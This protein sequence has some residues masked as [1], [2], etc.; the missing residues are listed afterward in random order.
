MKKK[1]IIYSLLLLIGLI[2]LTNCSSNEGSGQIKSNE[3][4]TTQPTE[5]PT[6]PKVTSTPEAT[7]TPEPIHNVLFFE[8]D[9]SQNTLDWEAR[10]GV[11][12]IGPDGLQLEMAKNEAMGPYQGLLAYPWETLQ[13]NGDCTFEVMMSG[14]YTFSGPMFNPSDDYYS[15][16]LN[17]TSV[18]L[19]RPSLG[20]K[21]WDA[22]GEYKKQT[23]SSDNN[24]T[25]KLVFI[26]N[27]VQVY[28]NDELIATRTDEIFDLP[29]TFGGFFVVNGDKFGVSEIKVWG[30]TLDDLQI[31]SKFVNE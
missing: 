9:F 7:A 23:S 21:A 11:T 3:V 2:G 31:D 29:K 1:L 22:L 20:D 28:V 8:E 26:G 27:E 4:P 18:G 16:I 12:N 25:I 19:L 10:K 24:V 15:F 6:E 30:N 17:P 5:Q 14:D 13:V